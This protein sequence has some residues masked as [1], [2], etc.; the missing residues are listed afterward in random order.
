MWHM[1]RVSGRWFWYQFLL[2]R[3]WVILRLKNHIQLLYTFVLKHIVEF[4]VAEGLKVA[5]KLFPE[6]LTTGTAPV[7]L[8]GV[9]ARVSRP[10]DQTQ[11]T[12][13]DINKVE[14]YLDSVLQDKGATSEFV[15]LNWLQSHSWWCTVC[16]FERNK[17]QVQ[18]LF[19]TRSRMKVYNNICRLHLSMLLKSSVRWP[20]SELNKL[21]G[22]CSSAMSLYSVA[23]YT[24]DFL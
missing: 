23:D 7:E 10:A 19:V 5:L 14:I 18:T 8:T 11:F 15:Y 17:L 3:T 22:P 6:G 21:N 9:K 12:N 13:E 1:T 4:V 20:G 16:Q 2:R 24:D